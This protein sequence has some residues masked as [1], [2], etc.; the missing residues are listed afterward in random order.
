MMPLLFSTTTCLAK[1]TT[2]NI[3][4]HL[5]S[6][7]PDTGDHVQAQ[8]HSSRR[9]RLCQMEHIPELWF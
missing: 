5:V 8:P 3:G 4:A 9:K 2:I 6:E 7:K 1:E